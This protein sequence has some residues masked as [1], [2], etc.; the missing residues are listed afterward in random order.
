MG[1]AL[2]LYAG[3]KPEPGLVAVVYDRPTVVS[4]G[5]LAFDPDVLDLEV[6]YLSPCYEGL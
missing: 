4:I 6:R 1:I 5:Y 3:I 2:H